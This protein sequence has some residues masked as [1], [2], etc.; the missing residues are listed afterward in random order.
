MYFARSY[1]NSNDLGAD[2]VVDYGASSMGLLFGR[3][4]GTGTG[5]DPMRDSAGVVGFK[6]VGR[7]VPN[8]HTD[9]PR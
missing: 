8:P 3:A 6:S 7:S 5:T 4:T 2:I 1:P 9:T